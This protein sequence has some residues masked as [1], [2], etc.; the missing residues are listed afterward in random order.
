MRHLLL[1]AA[2]C[3]LLSAATAASALQHTFDW[4]GGQ[5][6][7]GGFY[8]HTF[9]AYMPGPGEYISGARVHI[10]DAW[11]HDYNAVDK[12]TVFMADDPT[13][14]LPWDSPGVNSISNYDGLGAGPRT[15]IGTLTATEGYP[16]NP[17]TKAFELT[18]GTLDLFRNYMDT[19]APFHGNVGFGYQFEGTWELY[20][21]GV[22]YDVSHVQQR[23]IP[24][25]MSALLAT[26]GLTLVTGRKRL[27][28]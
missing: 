22:I 5:P 23:P 6:I 25:P 28:R 2:I 24:E 26:L 3:C 10:L 7:T 20:R 1:V 15:Y 19:R 11:S 13:V 4:G 18:G 8:T 17:A 16:G 21:G 27:R 14:D 9:I 12:I